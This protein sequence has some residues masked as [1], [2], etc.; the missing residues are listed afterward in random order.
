M[1]TFPF[2]ADLTQRRDTL[3]IPSKTARILLSACVLAATISHAFGEN[4]L[5]ET[6]SLIHI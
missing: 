6:L 3:E 4:M 2:N 5:E 1:T